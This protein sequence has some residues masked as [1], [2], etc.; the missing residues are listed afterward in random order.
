MAH[1]FVITKGGWKY[2]EDFFQSYKLPT[3]LTR[4]VD[5]KDFFNSM[6]RRRAVRKGRPHQFHFPDDL[7]RNE[8]SL[9]VQELRKEK[10]VAYKKGLDFIHQF[11]SSYDPLSSFTPFEEKIKFLI[12]YFEDLMQTLK[13]KREA[14]IRDNLDKA[15]LV[16]VKPIFVKPIPSGNYVM[17]KK[18]K[19]NV[20]MPIIG[21]PS[22]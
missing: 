14:V 6:F 2:F 8:F 3:A 7:S 4:F 1:Q 19:Y 20:L 13:E 12:I 10:W 22:T 11:D 17:H 16:L 9:D 18:A 15:R 21:E 5:P